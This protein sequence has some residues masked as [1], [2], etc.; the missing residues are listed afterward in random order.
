MIKWTHVYPNPVLEVSKVIKLGLSKFSL[1]LSFL[2][3][4]SEVNTGLV[5]Q[6]SI[7]LLRLTGGSFGI[8]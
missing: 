2:F 7:V 4:N 6:L 1:F 3:P 8:D 5:L